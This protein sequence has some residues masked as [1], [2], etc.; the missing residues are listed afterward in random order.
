MTFAESMISRARSTPRALVLP[1][2]T[3]PRTLRAA[4]RIADERIASSVTVVGAAAA[5]R[6]AAA[7]EGVTLDGIEVADPATSPDRDRFVEEFHRLRKHKGVTVDDARRAMASPLNWG[8]M[9]VSL[10]KAHSM[11]AGAESSTADVLRAAIPIIRTA[12]GTSYASSCFVMVVPGC[13]M[14]A[15][16]SFIFSDCAII[17]DPSA[18]QLAEIAL[19]AA[20]SCRALLQ[21]EPIVAMLSFSTR[22]SASHPSVDK[23]VRALE[24]ARQKAPGL[25]IDGEMQADA[26]LIASVGERKAPGSPVA[27]R[28]NTL[29]FPDLNAANIGYKLVQRLAKA[30]AYGPFLQGFSKPVSDLSRGCSADDI[31][32]TAAVTLVQ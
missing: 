19:A 16:G 17:P 31:V 12:P 15:A 13:A 26:A 32:V 1:E 5:V 4:R 21:A 20:T 10:G 11:V 22:G 6:A 30:E 2:G 8:A 23:V 7:K 29:V 18:E 9:M 3:E 25:Q 14:G 27:G 28:A 24:I